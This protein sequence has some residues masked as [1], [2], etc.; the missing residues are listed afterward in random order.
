MMGFA[1]ALPILHT[2]HWIVR[3]RGGVILV[4]IELVVIE[5]RVN[6]CAYENTDS[7]P[8]IVTINT[9]RSQ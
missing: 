4:V 1:V 3:V 7:S 8:E 9:T 5:V 6:R 2:T